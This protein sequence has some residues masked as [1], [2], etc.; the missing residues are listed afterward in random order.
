M[1]EA[2]WSFCGYLSYFFVWVV[3]IYYLHL[4]MNQLF[5]LFFYLFY[6]CYWGIAKMHYLQTIFFVVACVN[7]GLFFVSYLINT[8][9]F[10]VLKLQSFF[11]LQQ[12]ASQSAQDSSHVCSPT[13]VEI[14]FL[15]DNA[16]DDQSERREEIE[17]VLNYCFLLAA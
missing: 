9:F 3:N 12:Q 11:F 17:M 16:N 14:S 6:N 8:W 4:L 13:A 15:S 1:V 2:L 10:P 5:K 7:K